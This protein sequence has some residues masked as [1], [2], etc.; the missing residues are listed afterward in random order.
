MALCMFN[1]YSTNRNSGANT[2]NMYYDPSGPNMKPKRA[3]SRSKGSMRSASPL[4][5]GSV[6]YDT[7]SMASGMSR[8]EANQ[9]MRERAASLWLEQLRDTHER[10]KETARRGSEIQQIKQHRAVSQIQHQEMSFSANRRSHNDYLARR[11][12]AFKD[13]ED[14]LRDAKEHT[15]MLDSVRQSEIERESYER[16][17]AADRQHHNVL[18]Q[19]IISTGAKNRARSENVKKN[20]QHIERRRDSISRTKLLREQQKQEQI[21][22]DKENNLNFKRQL[23][24]ERDG[25]RRDTAQRAS[26]ISEIKRRNAEQKIYHDED[27][28]NSVLRR[29]DSWLRQR[30]VQNKEKQDQIKGQV[31][32]ANAIRGMREQQY[33]Q[34]FQ[35]SVAIGKEMAEHNKLFKP[36]NAMMHKVCFY[37]IR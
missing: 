14:Y 3:A 2:T 28:S 24:A 32:R 35:E 26:A 4:A 33:D 19:R 8:L 20:T 17:D 9:S 11:S 5:G 27:R 29:R 13:R 34:R 1:L 6:R 22:Y 15:E 12:Q 7:T 25:Y 31:D 36:N 23:A 21:L 30:S 37:L 18:S 10:R 16:Q